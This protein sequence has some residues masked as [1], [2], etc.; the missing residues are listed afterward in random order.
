MSDYRQLVNVF[1]SCTLPPERQT[2]SPADGLFDECMS[3][4]STQGN[5]GVEIA[6]I[7]TFS[8][9][10]DMH[11]DLYRVAQLFYG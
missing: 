11:Y 2:K 5:D 8:Q 4:S 6:N 1:H 10:I 3:I 7:P 9:H